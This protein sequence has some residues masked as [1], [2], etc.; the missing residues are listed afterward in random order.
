ML[1]E[2]SSTYASEESAA[3]QSDLTKRKSFAL[4]LKKI[5]ELRTGLADYR[6]IKSKLLAQEFEDVPRRAEL[7]GHHLSV[8]YSFKMSEALLLSAINDVLRNENKFEAIEDITAEKLA[9]SLAGIDKRHKSIRSLNSMAAAVASNLEKSKKRTFSITTKNGTNWDEL[10]EGRKTAI[11]LDLILGFD[12]NT[13][14]LIIDQP[15]DNL[16]AD[17]INDGLA[18][19]IKG[20]KATRQ[21][22][23]VTHNA[24]IPMLADAQTVVLC[25]NIDGKL[26]I[27]SAR[28]EGFIDGK[29]AL[30]WIV[31]IT[32]GGEPSVQKRFRK[33]NFK[34]FGGR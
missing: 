25:R 24:T 6:S 30:D 28:L 12:G 11:L 29:R 15:K 33:Y 5:V 20:S 14:P 2:H 27:R 31:E 23:V 7:A 32:D 26:V 3:K 17:Y 21:T 22:I 8:V 4:V 13:A 18:A 1:K 16:A 19:A 34:R 10:S 9:A